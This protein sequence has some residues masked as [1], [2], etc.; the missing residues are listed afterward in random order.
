MEDRPLNLAPASVADYRE[1]ARK[2]LPRQLFD[3]IDGGAYKESTMRA[4]ATTCLR[5][6]RVGVVTPE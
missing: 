3:Y 6:L 4:A 2:K 1:L 5:V